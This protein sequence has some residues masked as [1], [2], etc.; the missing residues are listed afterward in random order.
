L[1]KTLIVAKEKL[2]KKIF[3]LMIV[4]D[5]DQN[6]HLKTTPMQKNTFQLGEE[7]PYGFLT[8]H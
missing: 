4:G 3:L 8:T 6:L 7:Q 2:Q 5:V 1:H